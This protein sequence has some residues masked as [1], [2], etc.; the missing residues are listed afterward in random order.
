[1]SV[2]EEQQLIRQTVGTAASSGTRDKSHVGGA[3][4]KK[5]VEGSFSFQETRRSK[6]QRCL[7]GMLNAR[8]VR[9]ASSSGSSRAS[10]GVWVR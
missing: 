9:I 5:D 6:C 4:R 1:V 3:K 8:L 2:N 10:A 7:C